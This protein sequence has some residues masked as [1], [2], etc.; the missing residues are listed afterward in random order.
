MYDGRFSQLP[1]YASSE[2]VGLL[3]AETVM[4]WVAAHFTDEVGLLEEQS[5][6]DVLRYAEDADNHVFMSRRATAFDAL[7]AFERFSTRGKSLDA[8]LLTD[9]GRQDQAPLGIVTI[10]D[11]PRLLE[12]T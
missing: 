11:V 9:G 4:R 1:V 12:L 7:D 2:F 10:F 6:G 8:I 5:V 3:T